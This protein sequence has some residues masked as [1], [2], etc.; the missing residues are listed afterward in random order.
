MTDTIDPA[1]ITRGL[2]KIRLMRR[3]LFFIILAFAPLV[4]FLT[5]FDLAEGTVIMSGI[6]WIAAGIILEFVIGFSR[7]PACRKHFHVRGMTGNF[8]TKKCMNCDTSLH[9]EI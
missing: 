7:C 8:F 4:Y 6:I 1:Q 9:G 3:L 2:R 5:M